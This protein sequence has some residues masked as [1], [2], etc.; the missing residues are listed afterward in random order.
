MEIRLSE[1]TLTFF[2]SFTFFHNFFFKYRTTN[3]NNS[4][5]H[6]IHF[7]LSKFIVYISL[8]GGAF[9]DY[10]SELSAHDTYSFLGG[11]GLNS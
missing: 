8:S 3:S 6:K 5:I 4:I 9:Q 7:D 2:S 1:I 11:G 10:L